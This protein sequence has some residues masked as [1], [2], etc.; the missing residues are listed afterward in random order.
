MSIL[1]EPPSPMDLY[2]YLVDKKLD[3]CTGSGLEAI[4]TDCLRRHTLWGDPS[5]LRLRNN[6]NIGRKNDPMTILPG[7]R[8][9][10]VFSDS[11]EAF[12][13]DLHHP[14]GDTFQRTLL[15]SSATSTPPR[16]LTA[17]VQTQEAGFQ[18]ELKMAVFSSAGSDEHRIRVWLLRPLYDVVT[19][20]VDGLKAE[21]L[22]SFSGHPYSVQRFHSISGPFLGCAIRIEDTDKLYGVVIDW[23]KADGTEDWGTIPKYVLPFGKCC[24]IGSGV[25]YPIHRGRVHF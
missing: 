17:V 2:S 5:S 14:S 19:G 22:S 20:H 15:S 23:T 9:A 21:L 1:L 18:T 13:L 11:G 3:M 4:V 10:I 6:V 8:W 25:G 12:V 24:R 7:G 16:Q